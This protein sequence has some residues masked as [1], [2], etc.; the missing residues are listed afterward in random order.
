M[1]EFPLLSPLENECL[2]CEKKL[3]GRSDKKFCNDTCRNLYNRNR[4][5]NA[6]EWRSD[7]EEGIIKAI[8]K[9][10]DI[11]KNASTFKTFPFTYSRHEMLDQG[12]HFKF[13]TSIRENKSNHEI[14]YFCFEYGYK[15]L[16]AEKVI[17][18]YND[19]QAYI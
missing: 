6:P 15:L 8:K 7:K 1:R 4:K 13:H 10:Y 17:I 18:V 3:S 5:K 12:F 2:Q 14:Y 16:S 9:N 11:L 19:N